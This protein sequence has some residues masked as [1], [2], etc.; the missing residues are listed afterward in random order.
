M[1]MISHSSLVNG[2]RADCFPNPSGCPENCRFFIPSDDAIILAEG[3]KKY[4]KKGEE[5]SANQSK[6]SDR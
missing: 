6:S 1:E 5:D 4:L 2:C 3:A